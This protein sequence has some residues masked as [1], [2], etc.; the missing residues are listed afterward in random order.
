MI[1]DYLKINYTD[2]NYLLP[3][4]KIDFTI[5]VNDVTGETDG[6][7]TGDYF[8][9]KIIKYESGRTIIQGS[10]HKY[11]NQ[12]DFN[13]ND[14]NFENLYKAIIDL[15]NEININPEYCKLENLEIGVNVQLPFC[16]NKILKNLLFHKS[17]E[18]TKPISGAYYYQSEKNEYIIK[19]YNKTEQYLQRLSK[20][21]TELKQNSVSKE[22]KNELEKLQSI[23]E[24]DLKKNTMRFEVKYT[25]MG[26]LNNLGVSSLSDLIK[27]EILT[28]FKTIILN[29]F[30]EV[31]FYDYT[32]NEKTM[33]QRERIKIKDYRNPNYFTNLNK[34]DKYYHRNRLDEIT[35]KY[36]QQTKNE[37]MEI[38]SKK[39]DDLIEKKLD[40]LTE[41]LDNNKK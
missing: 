19:I 24:K 13:G 38:L 7:K 37:V 10:I 16:P 1:P 4:N 6:K 15:K 31:Y 26:I 21:V 25:K 23:I 12:S 34:R 40:F 5:A 39:M 32:I 33:T 36:S 41:N 20:V 30:Q 27:P 22:K 18:F 35:E 11:F 8:D 2:K 9:M 3:K 14:L 28:K 29:E 17:K